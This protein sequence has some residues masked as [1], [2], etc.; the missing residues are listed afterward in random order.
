MRI[1]VLWKRRYMG[2]D[3]ITDRYARLYELPRGL[4][5]AGDDVLGLCLSYR[6]A[7]VSRE[8][9]ALVGSGSLAWRGFTAGPAVIGGLPG[10][11]RAVLQELRA[12]QPDVLLGGSDAV[13]AV[14]TRYFS[15]RIGVPYVLDLY[16]N[17]ESFG[18]TRIPGL[19]S[20][21]RRALRGAAGITT[22]SDLLSEYVR[23]VA[24]GVPVKALEST[25]D[26]ALFSPRDRAAARERLGLP[27][28]E[29]LVG[30]SGSL[31]RNRGI[32][33]VYS[34]FE[35]ILSDDPSLH[36]VL[37]GD[38][39]RRALPPTHARVRFL[40]RIAH[41][42]M[43]NFFSA[44]DLALV[45]MIDTDFGRYAFPQ[46][47]Y[48]ILACRTP[49]LTADIGALARTLAAYPR[50][51][52]RAGDAADLVRAVREQLAAPQ[53]PELPIPTWSDQALRLDAFIR[54][55]VGGV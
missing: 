23:S 19:L 11:H 36:L 26:P 55:V 49:I 53:R 13:H 35:R 9:H 32:E 29:R 43:A 20:M 41:T 47:A 30:V 37:A 5:D 25:I 48:E 21:Y 22:V 45:P 51:L 6:P 12:F 54:E 38:V 17:F 46:K 7:V 52:Y 3:V 44:M 2:H 18:L 10:Y 4:A 28:A 8:A 24:I 15:V 1:A 31:G 39:D 40:G 50:C 42:E 27:T 33:V 34:A 14:L 16:D